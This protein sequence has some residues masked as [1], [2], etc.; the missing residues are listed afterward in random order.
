MADSHPF[1]NAGLGMFGTAERQYAQKGM[2]GGQGGGNLLG[3]SLA[4]L[5]QSFGI[6]QEDATQPVKPTQQTTEPQFPSSQSYKPIAPNYGMGNLPSTGVNPNGMSQYVAPNFAQP[7]QA[8]PTQQND[9]N[10]IS[11]F[12]LPR[13]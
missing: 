5:L 9:D 6:G 7:Q 3:G 4:A 1:S 10:Y 11:S 12:K 8:A 13:L 2:Q